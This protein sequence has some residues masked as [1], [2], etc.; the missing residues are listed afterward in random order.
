MKQLDKVFAKQLPEFSG[1]PPEVLQSIISFT[2]D[3]LTR[4]KKLSEIGLALSA[5]KDLDRLLEQIIQEARHLTNAD[6]GTLYLL[7]EKL[8]A[9][10]FAIVQ[11]ETLNIRMGGGGKSNNMGC[12]PPLQPGWQPQL[13]QC[14]SLFGPFPGSREYLGCLLRERIQF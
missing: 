9:L 3:Q 14:L 12:R 13:F 5:Q 8:S 11:N 6:G 4:V 7:D 10:R 2:N 1:L